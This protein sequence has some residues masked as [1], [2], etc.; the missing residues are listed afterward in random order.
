MRLLYYANGARYKVNGEWVFRKW[1][2][3]PSKA[4]LKD[5]GIHRS[6]MYKLRDELAQTGYIRFKVGIGRGTTE[7][8]LCLLHEA[9][10]AEPKPT[11]AYRSLPIRKRRNKGR[12]IRMISI[13]RLFGRPLGRTYRECTKLY[14]PQ[15]TKSDTL[16]VQN[17]TLPL[18]FLPFLLY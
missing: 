8:M 2:E 7:Y 18:R 14:T 3:V 11:E 12:S 5:T 4:L 1:V 9:Q 6:T 17:C 16:S 13:M 10:R 15:C